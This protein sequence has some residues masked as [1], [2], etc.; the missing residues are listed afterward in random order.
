MRERKTQRFSEDKR[1]PV[2]MLELRDILYRERDRL[3][4]PAFL[5]LTWKGQEALEVLRA[6]ERNHAKDATT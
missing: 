3:G 4:K 5:C 6:I 1:D 2:R